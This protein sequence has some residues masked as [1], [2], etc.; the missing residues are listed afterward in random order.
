VQL[1]SPLRED[2]QHVVDRF[3]TTV[4]WVLAAPL[5]PRE[6]ARQRVYLLTSGEFSSTFYFAYTWGQH[7]RPLPRSFVPISVAP[8]A[9]D[10]E[11]VADNALLLRTLG[12]GFLRSPSELHFRAAERPLRLGEVVQL[13]GL[14]IQVARVLAGK[15]DTLRLTFDRSIDDRSQVFLTSTVRG[16]ERLAMPAVGKSVRLPRAAGPNWAAL[17]R[18]R[19]EQRIGPLPAFVDFE[20][21]PAFAAF[22][23]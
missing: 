7:G 21:L 22:K 12:G 13:Q 2:L 1:V 19:Y 20:P 15:P 9:H 14:R 18:G 6:V 4:A 5:N 17:E 10:V 3:A 8:Y 11:R 16:I 23:P